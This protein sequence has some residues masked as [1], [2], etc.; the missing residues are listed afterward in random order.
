VRSDGRSRDVRLQRAKVTVPVV[1]SEMRESG[2]RR[3]GTSPCRASPTARAARCATR[4]KG[5]L[6]KGAKGIVLDLRDNGGGL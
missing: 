5:L 4:S 6:D 2:G 1:S 3:S